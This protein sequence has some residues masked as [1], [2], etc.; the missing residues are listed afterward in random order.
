MDQLTYKYFITG[1]IL[2][3]GFGPIILITT[4]VS[5]R[6]YFLRKRKSKRQSLTFTD[7]KHKGLPTQTVY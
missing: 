1:L 6:R 3:F 7:K 2:L 4:A 5:I